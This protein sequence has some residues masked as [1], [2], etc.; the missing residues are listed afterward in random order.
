MSKHGWEKI[1][2][3]V[4]FV[5]T[6]AIIATICVFSGIWSAV[7]CRWPIQAVGIGV[8]SF[9]L[10]CACII[11]LYR[12]KSPQWLEKYFIVG[13]ISYF[14]GY[15]YMVV[16]MFVNYFNSRDC[17]V[18]WPLYSVS[19]GLFFTGMIPLQSFFVPICLD[20]VDSIPE[21]IKKRYFQNT[22]FRMF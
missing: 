19:I 20:I 13:I 5:S 14:I 17:L 8:Y 6:C 7:G 10:L 12:C 1:A 16:A 9:P 11:G 21:G 2:G 4:Y 22:S 15:I 3:M 18:G